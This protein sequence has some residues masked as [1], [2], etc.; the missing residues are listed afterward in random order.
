M[1]DDDHISAEP[2]EEP[3]RGPSRGPAVGGYEGL[4]AGEAIAAVRVLGLRPCLER[5]EGYEAGLHGF[6]VSQEPSDGAEVSPD[7][8]VF[9]YVASPARTIVGNPTQDTRD[10]AMVETSDQARDVADARDSDGL[11]GGDVGNEDVED[12]AT[13][14][15]EAAEAVVEDAFASDLDRWEGHDD[16]ASDSSSAG[17]SDEFGASPEEDTRELGASGPAFAEESEG[18]EDFDGFADEPVEPARVWRGGL[19]GALPRRRLS[20]RRSSHEGVW[21]RLPLSVQLAVIALLGFSAV[22]VL[23]SLATGVRSSSRG[24]QRPRPVVS[25]TRSGGAR[26]VVARPP[27]V[28]ARPVVSPSVSSARAGRQRARRVAVRER[29]AIPSQSPTVPTPP[30]VSTAAPVPSPSGESAAATEEHAIREFG[31]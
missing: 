26:P 10:E 6:V 12:D 23:V 5:V 22:V 14:V 31:P 11:D 15:D 30:S 1:L 20:S 4:R 7:S 9:L 19:P 16:G 8:Q 17:C 3:V 13:G 21:R 29:T 28:T 24:T 18:G 25:G 27:V 2:S